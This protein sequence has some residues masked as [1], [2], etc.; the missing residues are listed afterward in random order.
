MPDHPKEKKRK[1]NKAGN[2][3]NRVPSLLLPSSLPESFPSSLVSKV[4]VRKLILVL[5]IGIVRSVLDGVDLAGGEVV[6]E[7]S[8]MMKEGAST[9]WKCWRSGI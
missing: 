1:P 6:E 9:S 3:L 5:C 7:E 8:A 4:Y 2:S